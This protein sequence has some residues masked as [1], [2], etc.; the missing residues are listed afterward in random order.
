[1]AGS[2]SALNSCSQPCERVV[3]RDPAVGV[4]RRRPVDLGRERPEARLVRLHLGRHRHRQQRATVEGV[5]EHD[6]R[7]P[8]GCGARDLDRV[9]DRLRPGVDEDR[10]LLV[11][12]A[13]GEL[14]EAPAHVDV[15]L[16]D[17]DHEALVQ[18]L[19]HLRLDRLDDGR[20]AVPGVL[21]ADAAGEV[22]EA[23]G[24]RRRRRARHR[25]AR[26]RDAGSRHP[27]RRSGPVRRGRHRGWCA[28]R[29]WSSQEYLAS[30]AHDPPE[31]ASTMRQRRSSSAGR[32]S[33]L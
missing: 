29:G 22:D 33:A 2:T 15:R 30:R 24:R 20:K 31:C 7:R 23:C 10:L 32:A 26:R 1:M 5:V 9:L 8:A 14:G 16:V 3:A 13:R 21:A 19:V 12:R 18:V 6:H 17:A 28:L 25:R 27:P 11:A 4:R